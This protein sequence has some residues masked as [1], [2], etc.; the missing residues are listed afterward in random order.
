MLR[1]GGVVHRLRIKYWPYLG[2]DPTVSATVGVDLKAVTPLLVLL[3]SS[4]VVSVVVLFLE[5]GRFWL[6][7]RRS[8]GRSRWERNAS[9]R[10]SALKLAVPKKPAIAPLCPA[11]KTHKSVPSYRTPNPLHGF[12]VK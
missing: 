3:T 9:R 1:D 6:R 4:V 11:V 2:H 8:Q 5:R 7:K 10:K 12:L